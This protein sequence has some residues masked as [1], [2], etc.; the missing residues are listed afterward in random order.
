MTNPLMDLIGGLK[1]QPRDA[2]PLTSIGK[3]QVT[4]PYLFEGILIDH[5]EKLAGDYVPDG[6]VSDEVTN[7]LGTVWGKGQN[8]KNGGGL[9]KH[10]NNKV[11]VVQENAEIVASYLTTKQ[12]ADF[13]EKH[14]FASKE[15]VYA[16]ICELPNV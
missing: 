14:G 11:R 8:G 1:R 7:H 6:V 15:E 10:G 16:K 12:F 9:W 13:C 3:M 4:A 5:E 2:K